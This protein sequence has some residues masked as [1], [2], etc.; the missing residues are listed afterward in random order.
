MC[1]ACYERSR[2]VPS[3]RR[4]RST[5]QCHPER[6]LHGRG[7]CTHC[8]GKWWKSVN[9]NP[10]P[11]DE[12]KLVNHLKKYGLTV[13]DYQALL[14]KQGGTCALCGVPPADGR[15]L[16]VD[17]D[18][19]TGRVRGLLCQRCNGGLGALGDDVAGLQRAIAYLGG[20]EQ[21]ESVIK[22]KVPLVGADIVLVD[23]DSTLYAFGELFGYG[24]PLTGVKTAIRMLKDSGY[25]I[26]IFSSR[27]STTWHRSEKWDTRVA[28]KQQ[29]EYISAVLRRDGIPFDA[30]TS[31]KVPS[32]LILDDKAMRVN[33]RRGILS[34]VRDF[35]AMGDMAV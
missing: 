25:R 12:R 9:T 31:E 11:T 28:A 27:L 17:H 33:S 14:D 26:V 24:K 13:A 29:R 32:V 20:R 3:P 23:F 30:I 21:D 5:A 10:Q 19:V 4:G 18:H 1:H 2:F 6:P 34:A 16:A 22:D 7:L 35:L 15:R 8:Y